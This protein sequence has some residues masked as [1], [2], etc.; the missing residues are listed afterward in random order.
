MSTETKTDGKRGWGGVDGLPPYP[1]DDSNG[2]VIVEKASNNKKLKSNND[3]D[4]L[5]EVKEETDSDFDELF[6]ES[7]DDKTITE[8]RN[9]TIHGMRPWKTRKWRSWFHPRCSKCHIWENSIPNGCF[10]GAAK[11]LYLRCFHQGYCVCIPH[12][13]LIQ[14][15]QPKIL[16][17]PHKRDVNAL[18]WAINAW[19]NEDMASCWSRILRY[20]EGDLGSAHPSRLSSKYKYRIWRFKEGPWVE[21]VRDSLEEAERLDYKRRLAQGKARPS[22][23]YK[24]YS[25]RGFS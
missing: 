5:E 13:R 2:S 20:T 24:Y 7:D 25:E 12:M 15:S 3:V 11:T 9:L 23:I 6:D 18:Y 17:A 16:H 8:D 10:D 22:E 19:V 21:I 14:G 4:H 1:G